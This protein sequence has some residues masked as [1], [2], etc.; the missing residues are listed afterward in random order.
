MPWLRFTAA[1]AY[2]PKR[3]VTISYRAGCEYRVTTACA[4]EAMRAGKAVLSP[5][6]RKDRTSKH[7]ADPG[8]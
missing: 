8:R 7:Y 4:K 3:G 1:F 5:D 2:A 6:Q